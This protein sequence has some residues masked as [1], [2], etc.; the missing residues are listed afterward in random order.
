M[1]LEMLDKHFYNQIHLDIAWEFTKLQTLKVERCDK[2]VSS[3]PALRYGKKVESDSKNTIFKKKS[4][5]EHTLDQVGFLI[6]PADERLATLLPPIIFGSDGIG[7]VLVESG[8]SK[9]ISY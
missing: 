3:H 8:G 1:C 6:L 2:S 9:Y 5:E 4:Q 7:T